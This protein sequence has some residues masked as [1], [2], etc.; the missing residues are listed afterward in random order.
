MAS[1]HDAK[2]AHEAKMLEYRSFIATLDG[3]ED[4]VQCPASDEAGFKSNC[5][6]CGLCS[7][8][9][10]KGRKDVKILVH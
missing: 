9:S 5:A 10:G 6:T 4:A 8:T 3:S 2:Q 1:V 7:G